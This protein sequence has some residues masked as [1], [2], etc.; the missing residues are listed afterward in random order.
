[1]NFLIPLG[2]LSPSYGARPTTKVYLLLAVFTERRNRCLANSPISRLFSSISFKL[3]WVPVTLG[4]EQVVF[5][6]SKD[7][8]N[9][10]L[11]LDVYVT[12]NL[13]F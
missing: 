7:F 3:L 5:E 9:F 11:I 2:I 6:E 4:I 1:M 13:F 10:F 8:H 12:K